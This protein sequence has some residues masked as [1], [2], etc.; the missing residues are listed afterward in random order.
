MQ[1]RINGKEEVVEPKKTL[2]EFIQEKGIDSRAVVI[3]HNYT[4]VEK[5]MWS[6]ILINEN[7]TIDSLLNRAD[8]LLYKSK[9]AGRSCLTIG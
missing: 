8:T 4:I 3:E 1:V 6:K 2:L 5:E 9:D 7:D